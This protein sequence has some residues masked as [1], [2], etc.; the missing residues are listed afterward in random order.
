MSSNQ[1]FLQNLY[2][3]FNLREVEAI[4]QRIRGYAVALIRQK[5]RPSRRVF[6]T[7]R[8]SRAFPHID[9]QS[10]KKPVVDG[11][12][13]SMKTDRVYALVF[14]GVYPHYVKKVESKG[15]TKEELH[16]VLRWLT[17]YTEAGLQKV[18]DDK[19]D[20]RTFFDL[21]PAMNPNVSLIK[22]TVCGIRVKDIEDP[23][24]QNIR[25]LDKLI[26]ELAKGKKM[27]KILRSAE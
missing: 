27:E 1:P 17:S 16:E 21:S 4:N 3:A 6:L 19:V 5:R 10:P 12:G 9:G 20:L 13:S 15:R 22:G 23:L 24:M 8:K 7:R 11:K 2:D 26:D 14:A 18:L 25:Y